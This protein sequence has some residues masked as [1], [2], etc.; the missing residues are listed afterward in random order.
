MPQSDKFLHNPGHLCLCKVQGGQKYSHVS[1]RVS[2]DLSK[3]LE[4]EV[5]RQGTTVNALIN[6]VLTRYLAFDRL[7]DYDHSVTLERGCFEKIIEK[8]S[9]EE[10]IHIAGILGPR[11]VKR[12]FAF[13][14]IVPNLDNL[15]LKHFEPT[16][17]YSDRF[18][19]NVSGEGPNLK[20]V[21]THEY[22]RKWS[23]FLAEYYDKAVGSVLGVKPFIKVEDDLVTIEFGSGAFSRAQE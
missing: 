15:I 11:T 13:F 23:N 19:L 4:K 22:G 18:D 1:I 14:D 5:R 12:D 9:G 21:L 20:L 2:S 8:L 6:R 16:G 7:A 10:L 17:A 3:E